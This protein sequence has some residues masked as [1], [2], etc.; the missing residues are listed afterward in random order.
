[1]KR[2]RPQWPKPHRA[3]I[4]PIYGGWLYVFKSRR[5]FEQA[6][7]YLKVTTVKDGADEG[8]P[9]AAK[10]GVARSLVNNKTGSR[11]FMVGWYDASVVTL[12]HE[13][14]HV[15]LFVL[16]QVGIDARNDAGEPL[17]YLQSA[18]LRECGLK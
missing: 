1:M 18:L 7:A 4:V 6:L 3:F 11:I 2:V 10:A 5:A 9:E 17:C 8:L 12:V 16:Q 15:A 14:T 13:L